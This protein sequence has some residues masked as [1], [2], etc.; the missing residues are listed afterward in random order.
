MSSKLEKMKVDFVK[1]N[2]LCENGEI[3]DEEI[4]FFIEMKVIENL[5]ELR[6]E[7]KIC[8]EAILTSV[9]TIKGWVVFWSILSIIS[10]T[11]YLAIAAR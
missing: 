7:N 10:L 3:A 5:K 1:D 9:N 4:K 6:K 8:M 2:D 11:I